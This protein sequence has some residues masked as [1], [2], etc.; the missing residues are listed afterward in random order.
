VEV[1]ASADGKGK[2]ISLVWYEKAMDLLKKSMDRKATS[3]SFQVT[4]GPDANVAYD[5]S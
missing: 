5:F 3:R 1:R 4:A 2:I